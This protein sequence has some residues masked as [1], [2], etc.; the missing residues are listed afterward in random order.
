ME[1]KEVPWEE[2]RKSGAQP[3]ASQFTG[4]LIEKLARFIGARTLV[5]IGVGF[6][7]V[8]TG[9]AVYASQVDGRY[10]GIE[11]QENRVVLVNEKIAEFGGFGHVIHGDSKKIKWDRQIDLL[12]VD[13]DHGYE[14]V[15]SDLGRFG[16]WVNLSGVVCC[17]DYGKY[18]EIKRACDEWWESRKESWDRLR[19]SSHRKDS[20]VVFRRMKDGQ[21]SEK[22][23]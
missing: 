1:I 15:K 17:H 8:S 9:L 16:K 2:I 4:P 22:G 19:L 6:G 5:E 10:H 14:A 23:G 18:T 3:A 12:F 11:V 21:K 13:G 20:L 7:F